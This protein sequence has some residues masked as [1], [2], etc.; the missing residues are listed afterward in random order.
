MDEIQQMSG[1]TNFNNLTYCLKVQMLLQTLLA[2]E[3]H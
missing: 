1:E 2:L 3:V